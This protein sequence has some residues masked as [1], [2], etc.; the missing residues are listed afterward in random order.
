MSHDAWTAPTGIMYAVQETV[1]GPPDGTLIGYL[2][3]FG[4]SDVP[5][6][7]GIRV[8]AYGLLT[9]TAQRH[10][11]FAL[12]GVTQASPAGAG[13]GVLSAGPVANQSFSV[14]YDETLIANSSTGCTVAYRLKVSGLLAAPIDATGTIVGGSGHATNQVQMQIQWDNLFNP[15]ATAGDSITVALIHTEFIG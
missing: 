4:G 15:D 12:T 3:Q 14:E 2:S 1:V 13:F 9:T 7:Q 6:G 8:R 11:N 10:L 5:I